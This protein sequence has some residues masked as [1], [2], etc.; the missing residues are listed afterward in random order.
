MF[1]KPIICPIINQ[2]RNSVISPIINNYT[3]DFHMEITPTPSC[4]V[5][6]TP[7]VSAERVILDVILNT[8]GVPAMG[9]LN[10]KYSG[11]LTSTGGDGIYHYSLWLGKLPAGITLNPETG[12]LSGT[13]YVD[14]VYEIGVEVWSSTKSD[15]ELLSI[16]ITK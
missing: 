14:G 11:Q 4:T 8:D 2:K 5:T 6:P 13:A 15:Q 9:Y 1:I 3:D 10:K 7:T 16:T 12:Y